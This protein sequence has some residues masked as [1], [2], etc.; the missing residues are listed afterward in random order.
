[1]TKMT[2]SLSGVAIALM[3][4]LS[5]AASANHNKIPTDFAPQLQI[6]A[7]PGAQL[8]G[9]ILQDSSAPLH[10]NFPFQ[11]RKSQQLTQNMVNMQLNN[12][13]TT[14]AER[15]GCPELALDSAV[16][17]NFS[18]EGQIQC[19]SVEITEA[20]KV[21]GLLVNIPAG[22]DY[23]LYLFKLEDDNSFT[24]LD[25]SNLATAT[26][27]QVV[28]KVEPGIYILAAES[29]QGVATEQAIMGWFSHP[30]FDAQE[31]NDKP[32]LATTM[33]SS[34][35]LQG[36]ID[37]Q[38]DLDFFTYQTGAA[39]SQV[40][41]NFSASE[42]FILELWTGTA[43][44]K[45]TNNQLLNVNVNPNSSVTLRARGDQNNLPPTAAQYAL[46]VSNVDAA[47]KLTSMNAWNNENLTNL[48]EPSLLEA[49]QEIGMSGKVIDDAGNAIPYAQVSL[50]VA[51]HT[52]QT[53][54][55]EDL[56]TDAQ[57]GFS[58]MV[59]LPDCTGTDSVVRRNRTY[60]GTPTNPELWWD[61]SYELADY[62]YFLT[63]SSGAIVHQFNHTF[64]HICKEKIVKSCYWQRDYQNGGEEYICNR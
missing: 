43:W 9:Q 52:G 18:A 59:A 28:H 41:L 55:S 39:Q 20:T 51:T 27:E 58:T 37:N 46:T 21:E 40:K 11:V 44:V 36:N 48:L 2:K 22:V 10:T 61:I 64:A 17:T 4:V 13:G 54:G 24:A 7:L 33:S 47:T 63:N 50:R 42:Q 53:I 30:E 1:M 6:E 26:T 49:H 19:Y 16:Y 15:S 31:A 8:D 62:Y 34:M 12:T 14:P 23:N 45:A 3:A 35:T 5:S 56:L 57:G 25:Y 60:R 32:A 38:N 29:T